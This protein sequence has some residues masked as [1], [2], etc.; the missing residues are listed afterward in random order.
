M[1][2]LPQIQIYLLTKP[3]KHVLGDNTDSISKRTHSA[4]KC[5]NL[6]PQVLAERIKTPQSSFHHFLKE[7]MFSKNLKK[8]LDNLLQRLSASRVPTDDLPG[9]F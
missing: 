8:I 5:Q 7:V 1:F 9:Q 3:I 4:K 2:L 6:S